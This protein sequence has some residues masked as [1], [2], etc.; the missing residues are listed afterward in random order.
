MRRGAL[1]KRG[2]P[3][4]DE[5]AA[6]LMAEGVPHELAR[7]IAFQLTMKFHPRELGGGDVWRAAGR[8]LIAETARLRDRIDLPQRSIVAALPKLSATQIEEL[9]EELSCADR[10]VARTILCA[11]LDAA[12]PLVTGRRFMAEYRLVA[13]RF[14]SIEP[15]LAR[16]VASITFSAGAP[17]EKAMQILRQVGGHQSAVISRQS[18]VVSRQSDDRLNR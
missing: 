7:R 16:T 17:L 6:A 10:R 5:I 15:A 9:F 1:G 2:T 14:R 13:H 12:E 8:L 4:R 18:S 3:V 11:A